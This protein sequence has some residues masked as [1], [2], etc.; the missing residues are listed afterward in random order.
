ML[1]HI[2]KIIAP[3]KNN[4]SAIPA[5]NVINLETALGVAKAAEKLR[6]PVIMQI[7][8]GAANYAGLEIIVDV[9]K[10]IAGDKK[11]SAPIAL[12]LDHG[13]D[14]TLIKKCLEL[15]FSSVHIDG[16]HYPLAKNIALTKKIVA[17]AK[18][19]GAW[20]QGE[21]GALPG[22]EDKIKN[23]KNKK[24]FLTNPLDAQKFLLATRVNTLAVSIG[25]EH[26][27]DKMRRANFPRLDW[28]RLAQIH[29]LLPHTPLVLH[30]ASGIKTADLTKARHL[31][32]KIV[33]IDTE[34]R[35]AF[36]NTMRQIL[37][38]D[39]WVYDPRKIL[40]PASLA[41]EKIAA[42]K[43]KQLCG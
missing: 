41:V 43:I 34:L 16:S 37:A 13:Q 35:L 31:G 6:Q 18:K 15:G 10:Q 24:F 39:A 14:L 40:G 25:N 42:K 29:Q 28:G 4:N 26:G 12:H 20:V 2:K 32:I 17:L 7:S 33:N 5:F 11:N 1:V 21:V 36:T 23:L 38:Q 30:G 3:L 8:E 9:L 19:Y 22:S 27:I